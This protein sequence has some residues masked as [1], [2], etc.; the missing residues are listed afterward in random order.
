[1]LNS[2]RLW[3]LV[4]L[5]MLVGCSTRVD[6]QS[7]SQKSTAGDRLKRS[8]FRA[9][10]IATVDNIDFPSR[11]GLA[12]PQLQDELRAIVAR[13]VE[14]RLNALVFQV[15]PA[16]DAFYRSKLEPWSEWLTGKQGKAP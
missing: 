4:L 8:E 1:M 11:K 14:L 3:L 12:V 13:A 2:R 15:R 5:F 7:R 6:A 16:G 10:W 9:A